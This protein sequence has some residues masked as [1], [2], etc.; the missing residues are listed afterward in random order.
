MTA[1]NNFFSDL[2]HLAESK[3]L[4]TEVLLSRMGLDRSALDSPEARVDT[5]NIAIIVD[6]LM[7]FLQDEAMGLAYSAVPRGSFYLLGKLAIHEGNLANALN[8]GVQFYA[9]VTEAY[10]IKLVLDGDFAYLSFNLRNPELDPK[11]LLAE[12]ILMSWHRFASWL[13][14]ES[15]T[16]HQVFFSYPAPQHVSEY[17]Y[18]FPGQHRFE[19]SSLAICFHK[20]FLE[21]PIAQSAETLEAFIQRGPKEF[22]KQPTTDFSLSHDIQRL[23]KKSLRDGFPMIDEMAAYLNMTKRTLIRKL[24]EEGTSYQQLK[25]L[26][27]RDRAIQLLT[28]QA[29]SMSEIAQQIGFSDPAVFARAF[30]TWT[31]VSPRHYRADSSTDLN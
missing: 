15:I 28:R 3:G 8:I 14:A 5:E 25:D 10:R 19:Q 18:L 9:M 13:I 6:S 24:K 27:R 26:V 17:A 30:K 2:F 4:N 12:I 22:F 7:D 23:L 20:K 31:G 11:H 21:R 1:A 29:I 16:L